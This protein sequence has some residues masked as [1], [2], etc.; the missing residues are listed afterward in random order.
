MIYYL[1]LFII[2]IMRKRVHQRC[3]GCKGGLIGTKR[4][5]QG[6]R[7]VQLFGVTF[8]ALCQRLECAGS[9]VQKTVVEVDHTQELLEL[10]GGHGLLF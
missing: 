6:G 10:F 9:L 1:L 8:E 7:P 3:G 5:L 2:I 4:R